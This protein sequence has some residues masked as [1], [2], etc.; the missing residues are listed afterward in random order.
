MSYGVRSRRLSKSDFSCRQKHMLMSKWVRGF[1]YKQYWLSGDVSF[2]T[3]VFRGVRRIWT[4][5]ATLSSSYS[6]AW[7]PFSYAL[8]ISAPEWSMKSFSAI[9]GLQGQSYGSA[10]CRRLITADKFWLINEK[11]QT[12]YIHKCLFWFWRD[13]SPPSGPGSFHSRSF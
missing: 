1:V 5:W 8:G 11:I 10:A 2:L 13:S 4:A 3:G 6:N 9:W 12:K 7:H